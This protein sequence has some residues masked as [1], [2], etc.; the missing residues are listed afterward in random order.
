MFK[1][2]SYYINITSFIISIIIFCSGNLFY[3]N[4]NFKT[5]D[6]TD[7]IFKISNIDDYQ[8][9]K[10]SHKNSNLNET[11]DN[12]TEEN[13]E[14]ITKENQLEN[15][16]AEDI[17]KIRDEE[18]IELSWYVKIPSIELIAQIAEGTDK[19]TMDKYVGHFDETSKFIGNVGLVAHNRGYE[20]NYFQDVKKLKKGDKIIYYYQ[21]QTIEYEV[22]EHRIIKDTDWSYLEDTK[23]NRITLITCVENEPSYRRC[24]QAIQK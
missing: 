6:G 1:Y 15:A 23:D 14:E 24:V 9:Q 2:S 4:F 22:I 16:N 8:N 11:K 3:S 5:F 20:N 17:Q 10:T 13:V 12:N 19:K 7:E 21:G 18:N